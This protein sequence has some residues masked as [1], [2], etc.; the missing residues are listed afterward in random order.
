MYKYLVNWQGY[1][2]SVNY[3]L[4]AGVHAKD[5]ENSILAF[6]QKNNCNIS[7]FNYAVYTS[8]P[9]TII[10]KSQLL[11][12]SKSRKNRIDKNELKTA[13]NLHYI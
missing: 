5:T 11:Q 8:N 2:N 7:L 12:K 10:D 9:T 3:T 6:I 13:T 1:N 4:I